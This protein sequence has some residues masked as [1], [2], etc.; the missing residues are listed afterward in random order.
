[1]LS[2]FRT[3]PGMASRELKNFKD[4]QKITKCGMWK[5]WLVWWTPDLAVLVG[6]VALFNCEI[7]FTL[8]V[9]LS[10]QVQM[11]HVLFNFYLG[12]KFFKA[13]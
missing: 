3:T 5:P 8:A 6:V 7:Y 12:F 9:P 13:V 4:L 2:A 1:M 10:S 11:S